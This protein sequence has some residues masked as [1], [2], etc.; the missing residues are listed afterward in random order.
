M[1]KLRKGLLIGIGIASVAKREAKKVL[2]AL[3]KQGR[4]NKPKAKK[5]AKTLIKKALQ[6]EKKLKDI[7]K[8]E[9]IRDLK[10]FKKR[11]KKF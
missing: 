7:V 10:A 4:L 9:L 3:E 5:L 2:N 11:A 1:G 6:K 8:R